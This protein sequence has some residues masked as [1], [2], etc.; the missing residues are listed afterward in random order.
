MIY[1]INILRL[2]LL[3]HHLFK[4]RSTSDYFYPS[5]VRIADHHLLEGSRPKVATW[6]PRLAKCYLLAPRPEISLS[7]CAK[8]GSPEAQFF[9]LA[10]SLE[11]SV[12]GFKTLMG[13]IFYQNIWTIFGSNLPIFKIWWNLNMKN[14]KYYPKVIIQNFK[15]FGALPENTEPSCLE[16][17]LCALVAWNMANTVFAVFR[18]TRTHDKVNITYA[19]QT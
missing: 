10:H 6:P 12:R 14:L 7:W 3:S 16:S 19:M 8:V 2:Y 13:N 17:V 18:A 1:V 9:L 11:Q 5:P 15:Y 4:I